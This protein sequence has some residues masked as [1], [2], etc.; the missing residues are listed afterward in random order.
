[1]TDAASVPRRFSTVLAGFLSGQ[2]ANRVL[3][4]LIGVVT[5]RLL[6]P[7]AYGR[8]VFIIAG[9]TLVQVAVDLGMTTYAVRSLAG[10]MRAGDG[11]FAVLVQT[12]A[13]IYLVAI[14]FLLALIWTAL[15]P[16]MLVL[17]VAA[18]WS[19]GYSR[20]AE[21]WLQAQ[22]K[23]HLASLAQVLGAMAQLCATVT[24]WYWRSVSMAVFAYTAGLVVTAIVNVLLR[25]DRQSALRQRVSVRQMFDTIRAC[26]PFAVL[27]ALAGAWYKLDPLMLRWL[28]SDRQIGLYSVA[29]RFV[30]GGIMFAGSV[31]IVLYPRM[32]TA[33]ASREELGRLFTRGVGISLALVIP[34]CI[35]GATHATLIMSL[36]VG[37]AY[38]DAAGILSVGLPML[39]PVALDS[40]ALTVF[41]A[42]GWERRLLLPCATRLV[43][44]ALINVLLMPRYGAT[45][46]I[47]SDL[48]SMSVSTSWFLAIIWRDACRFPLL[49]PGARLAGL[50]VGLLVPLLMFDNR[51]LWSAAILMLVAYGACTTILVPSVLRFARRPR[52]LI[53]V[54]RL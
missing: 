47:I 33:A 26:V 1:M 9:L 25:L 49:R 4:L 41:Y 23:V 15:D 50:I 7:A 34:I 46:A 24:V 38:S 29:F 37:P 10:N 53:E 14:P 35:V 16:L 2:V 11:T 43:L 39:V 31:A 27:A 40:M 32:V 44:N 54:A 19:S 8:Y 20:L 30:E 36:I 17:V 42:L 21:A 5:A 18:Y 28:A 3:G 22:Q 48:A 51:S 13:V 12:R 6:A 52:T 45:G